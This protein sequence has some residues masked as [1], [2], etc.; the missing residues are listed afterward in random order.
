MLLAGLTI[1]PFAPK[2]FYRESTFALI[3]SLRHQHTHDLGSRPTVHIPSVRSSVPESI[4][5]SAVQARRPTS[6][7]AA[8]SSSPHLSS[9]RIRRQSRAWP[10]TFLVS[11]ILPAHPG[12][13]SRMKAQ[14]HSIK[15]LNAKIETLVEENNALK[16]SWALNLETDGDWL[17]GLQHDRQNR[18]LRAVPAHFFT[19]EHVAEV[20]EV[21]RQLF[22]ELGDRYRASSEFIGFKQLSRQKREYET[23]LEGAERHLDE[24][25]HDH[26]VLKGRYENALSEM[27][28]EKERLQAEIKRLNSFNAL[29]TKREKELYDESIGD[30]QAQLQLQRE[31]SLYFERELLLK[32]LE[33][34]GTD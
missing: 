26:R 3:S 31:T 30:L 16:R 25:G 28:A 17:A 4:T 32:R 20:S 11:K 6:A 18:G 8:A 24:A 5:M 2:A 22:V 12:R 7:P 1:I 14:L 10:S 34:G 19:D 33:M 9:H 13:S 29:E 23:A 27:E 15:L 21:R